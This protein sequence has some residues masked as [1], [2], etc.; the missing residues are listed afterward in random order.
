MPNSSTLLPVKMFYVCYFKGSS[1]D[2]CWKLAVAINAGIH[3]IRYVQIS[4]DT[5]CDPIK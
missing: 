4:M 5:T 1:R 3:C 2:I